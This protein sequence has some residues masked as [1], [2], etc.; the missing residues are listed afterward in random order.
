MVPFPNSDGIVDDVGPIFVY[1]YGLLRIISR[2]ISETSFDVIFAE[3][4]RDAIKKEE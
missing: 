1:S 2:N 3:K 4:E